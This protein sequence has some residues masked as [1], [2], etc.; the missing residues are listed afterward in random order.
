[1]ILR[2][3]QGSRGRRSAIESEL[4]KQGGKMNFEDA[5]QGKLPRLFSFHLNW[6]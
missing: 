5:K 2:I 1:M 6:L 3:R 4:P